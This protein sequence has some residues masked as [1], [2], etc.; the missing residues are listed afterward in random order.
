MR[1][2]ERTE[3]SLPSSGF[4]MRRCG[5]NAC[6]ASTKM[7]HGGSLHALI[8]CTKSDEGGHTACFDPSRSMASGSSD[9]TQTSELE[10]DQAD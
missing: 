1:A 6:L 9:C 4:F 8:A 3:D 10:S 2:S 7:A 5:N